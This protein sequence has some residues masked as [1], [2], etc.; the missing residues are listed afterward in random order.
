MSSNK[1]TVLL[2]EDNEE[3]RRLYRVAF[4]HHNFTV[5]EAADGQSAVDEAILHMPS[6]I[7][8]DL[9]LPRQGGLAALRVLRT[10]PESKHIPIIILTAL[11]NPEYREVAGTRVQ[12]FY[13][14]TEITPKELIAK[15][16]ALLTN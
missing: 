14:K 5:L 15:A 16:E 6:L 10:L 4:Q 7:I 8:L 13:L 2:V 9:M 3:L 11:P 12:G 1:R